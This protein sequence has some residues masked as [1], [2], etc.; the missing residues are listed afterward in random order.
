MG[1]LDIR[2]QNA[3]MGSPRRAAIEE[4]ILAAAANPEGVIAIALGAELNFFLRAYNCP[5]GGIFTA[6]ERQALLG[7]Y[8]MAASSDEDR[9]VLE[10]M[11]PEEFVIRAVYFSKRFWAGLD[12]IGALSFADFSGM[13]PMLNMVA[14]PHPGASTL[15]KKWV[16][17]WIITERCPT[18]LARLVPRVAIGG[19][20]PLLLDLIGSRSRPE[21][22]DS[23]LLMGE[24]LLGTETSPPDVMNTPA[25][26]PLSLRR[27][28][29]ATLCSIGDA[30]ANDFLCQQLKN[31]QLVAVRPE[32]AKAVGLLSQGNA[33]LVAVFPRLRCSR[34]STGPVKKSWRV[35]FFKRHT[36]V[37]CSSCGKSG[38][39]GTPAS[40]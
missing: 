9:G 12:A 27:S 15:C 39:L 6:P 24:R 21:F 40:K 1:D 7:K 36:G 17:E 18:E 30:G 28:L 3:P 29:L 26:D 4:E 32:I 2:I 23:V 33:K 35:G 34:C 20:Y 25:S 38:F 11:S 16:L 14:H 22:L 19:V 8:R 5:D 10:G 13:E 31:V 37:V